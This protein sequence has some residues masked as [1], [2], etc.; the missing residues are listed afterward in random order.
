MSACECAA[1]RARHA[2]DCIED[3]LTGRE[4]T[5]IQAASEEIVRDS[6]K[7][8]SLYRC[9]ACGM[10]WV[11]TYLTSGHAELQHMYPLPVSADDSLQWMREHGEPLPR[12]EWLTL[13][14]NSKT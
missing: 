13:M 6:S 11:E 9:R 7:W 1:L 4:V 14:R 10:H 12:R 5:A 3:S 8:A 2:F